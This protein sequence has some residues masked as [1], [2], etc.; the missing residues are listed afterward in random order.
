MAKDNIYDQIITELIFRAEQNASSFGPQLVIS[1]SLEDNNI[2]PYSTSLS[3][4]ITSEVI[5]VP[6]GYTVKANTH[7]IAYPMGV[8]ATDVSSATIITGTTIN[9][10]S[11]TS[12]WTYVVTVSITL[13]KTASPDIVLSETFTI[14]AIESAYYKAHATDFNWNLGGAT[15]TILDLTNGSDVAWNIAATN[16]YL[17]FIVPTG[18]TISHIVDHNNNIIP[19]SNFTMNTVSSYDYYVLNWATQLTP[20]MIYNWKIIF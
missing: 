10:N 8:P 11:G 5:N 15:A 18:V 7:T 17:Y 13:E 3:F 6:V 4:E 16:L 19:I 14:T 20:A 12:G 1:S 2:V 9:V